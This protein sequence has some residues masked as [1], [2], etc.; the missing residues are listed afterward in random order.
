MGAAVWSVS[1]AKF[2]IC[3]ILR[4]DFISYVTIFL[5][6]DIITF[7]A[8]INAFPLY[9]VLLTAVYLYLIL[10]FHAISCNS[11]TISCRTAFFISIH[12]M[13]FGMA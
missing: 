5:F 1:F 11:F 8:Y 12:I 3:F 13:H 7:S 2:P 10:Q 9:P 6:R 4:S